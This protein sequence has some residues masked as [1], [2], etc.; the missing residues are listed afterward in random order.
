VPFLLSGGTALG[1]GRGDVISTVLARGDYHW[2][3]VIADQGMSTAK[4]YSEL[5][6]QRDNRPAVLEPPDTADGV[7]SAVRIGD[8]VALGRSL[9]NDLQRIAVSLQPQLGRVLEAGREAGAVG[10]IVSGSGPS[11]ALLARDGDDAVSI[12][13]FISGSGLCR[14]VRHA[15]GPVSGARILT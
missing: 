12:A 13:S 1:T 4:V 6:R 10:G 9:H 15:A 2:V 3:I 11:V 14:A 7:L 5:D 8:V